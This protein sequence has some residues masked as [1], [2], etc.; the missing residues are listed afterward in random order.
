MSRLLSEVDI[1]NQ[2]LQDKVD[3]LEKDVSKLTDNNINLH[4]N[5]AAARKQIKEL[6]ETELKFNKLDKDY[7]FV[8]KVLHQIAL[9]TIENSTE[10]AKRKLKDIGE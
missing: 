4:D 8:L 1:L 5:L 6:K 10:Y 7:K 9:G 2:R 3:R